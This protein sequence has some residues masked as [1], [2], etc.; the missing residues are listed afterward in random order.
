MVSKYAGRLKKFYSKWLT[1][2]DNPIVL[3]WISG[4]TL[5]FIK[6]PTQSKVPKSINRLNAE[7]QLISCEI[8]NL[9][10]SGAI[11]KCNPTPGQFLS[12]IFL[13]DKPNGGKRFI[14][15]LKR[16]NEF[17]YAP[18]FQMEDART[19]SKLVH[20]G[21]YAATL[22]LKDA[23]YLLP[24]QSS[25]RKYLRFMFKG[26]LYEFTCLPFGLASAPFV[27][28][29][30]MKPIIN[31]IRTR[32]VSCV[33]YLDDFL[34]LGSTSDTCSRNICFIASLLISLGFIIN[35]QKSVTSPSREFKFLGFIFNSNDMTMELPLVKRQ[36]ILDWIKFFKTH[37]TCKIL[38]F[39][40]F[41]GLL[42][43]ACP[44]IKYG[45]LYTKRLEREKFLAL[46]RNSQNYNSIMCISDAI[47]KEIYWWEN[48]I[49]TS[50]NDLRRDHFHL[51]IFT[52]ASLSGWGAFCQGESTCGRW[53]IEESNIHI[54]I[55]E[56]KAIYFGLK[57][58]ARDLSNC[59]ILIRTDNST[60]LAYVNKM[61]SVQHPQLNDL[62]RTIW[63]WCESRN[64]WIFASYISSSENWQADRASRVLHAE[65][66]WSLNQH[67]FDNI[68]Q[69]FGSPDIDLFASLANHKCNRYISWLRD[70]GSET[71]DAF[72]VSWKHLNFYAFPPFSLVLRV[73]QKIISD[74][75]VG[76]LVV[77][78][79][80][81]QPWYPLFVSLI[82]GKPIYFGPKSDLLLC[83][84]SQRR[85]PLSR[86]LILAAAK[87][88]GKPSKERGSRQ[89]P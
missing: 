81:C 78:L 28:T 62:S 40:Q 2:T 13:A 34:I 8:S 12:P 14:L 52:D 18:H 61:G 38:K 87:L 54:N 31:H 56:L 74:E 43:S 32:G 25:H 45:W 66:E 37:S 44:A 9:L 73:L 48:H 30:V 64:L 17:I 86:D 80:Q 10:S 36:K 41:L 39:A 83:P 67:V 84:F 68:T 69:S 72:T 47:I 7:D 65:T 71:I 89:K 59:N 49:Y 15:N 88:S 53:T 27:F 79:W 57:C 76:I 55:L 82:I 4:Y 3:G 6:T 35:W 23:Y 85:H 24:I 5:P 11:E 42:T 50:K 77:P 63:K 46:I 19:A 51:E 22:D 20:R 26:T 75:A 21:N 60:A 16:L 29:K 70:P 33:I 58:F 1:L